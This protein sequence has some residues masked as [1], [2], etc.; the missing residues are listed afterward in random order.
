MISMRV[1]VCVF[2]VWFGSL[3]LSSHVR[4]DDGFR[5]QFSLF[6]LGA[7]RVWFDWSVCWL[8]VVWPED[9]VDGWFGFLISLHIFAR[10]C[11]CSEVYMFW[12][13]TGPK[14][15]D[16]LD[17]DFGVHDGLKW[18]FH[19]FG[20]EWNGVGL[21]TWSANC[22]R[23]VW[24][25]S[26]GVVGCG[27]R[28]VG[29]DSVHSVCCCFHCVQTDLRVRNGLIRLICLMVFAVVGRWAWRLC[30]RSGGLRFAADEPHDDT[31]ALPFHGDDVLRSAA[32]LQLL[33][34]LPLWRRGKLGCVD[35][36]CCV[37]SIPPPQQR[38]R[39]TGPAGFPRNSAKNR[40]ESIVCVCVPPRLWTIAARFV[41]LCF[42]QCASFI[43]NKINRSSRRARAPGPIWISKHA[44]P[45]AHVRIT[46]A[47]MHVQSSRRRKARSQARWHLDVCMCVCERGTSFSGKWAG[48]WTSA[49][50]LGK[51]WS[52][53]V[54]LWCAMCSV[55]YA[56][57]VIYSDMRVIVC[58]IV[59]DCRD[60]TKVQMCNFQMMCGNMRHPVGSGKFNGVAAQRIIET[61]VRWYTWTDASEYFL[62]NV[63]NSKTF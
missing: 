63:I 57:L 24:R 59:W 56:N 49:L 33:P 10:F 61:I 38:G 5:M 15:T 1:G 40:R 47:C 46:Y 3:C 21:K 26:D 27:F 48:R 28:T 58:V 45:S 7:K 52:V 34:S 42:Q 54:E 31:R 55:L 53:V 36:Q 62:H 29:Q 35:P 16:S 17:D 22:I 14:R 13:R 41:P 20:T 37:A 2:F 12:K 25:L 11:G 51:W 8:L 18:S 9:Y 6:S 50:C 60:Q 39:R 4:I 19:Y 44:H 30:R 43:V 23:D 32:R